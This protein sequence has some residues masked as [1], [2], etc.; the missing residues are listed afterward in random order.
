MRVLCISQHISSAPCTLSCSY[1]SERSSLCK[2]STRV[3][4]PGE[5][6]NPFCFINARCLS[7]DAA[8]ASL[9]GRCGK[10][11]FSLS[12]LSALEACV[13]LWLSELKGK[14]SGG[15][16]GVW[17]E[18]TGDPW[19]EIWQP[20]RRQP[21]VLVPRCKISASADGSGHF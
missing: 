17:S 11:T 3:K 18:L 8:R 4:H 20:L 10:T 21:C 12:L 2:Q 19:N 5:R 9:K 14:P 7:E 16:K 15:S 6:R 1:I 13:C